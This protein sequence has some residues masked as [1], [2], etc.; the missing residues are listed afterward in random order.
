MTYNLFVI[1]ELNNTKPINPFSSL[2]TSTK[3]R[4]LIQPF[5]IKNA[6]NVKPQPY[7]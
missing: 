3:K 2:P 4:K 6:K 1:M 5:I 7:S